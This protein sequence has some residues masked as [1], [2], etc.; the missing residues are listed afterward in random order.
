MDK[1]KVYI[2]H[3]G[4]VRVDWAIPLHEKNPLAVI[5]L[6]RSREKQMALIVSAYFSKLFSQPRIPSFT[7]DNKLAEKCLT[8]H[9]M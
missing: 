2:F 9:K 6:F 5:R 7:A 8:V 4:K 1:I 3:T